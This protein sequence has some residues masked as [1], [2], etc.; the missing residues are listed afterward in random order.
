[1]LQP[2]PTWQL[3]QP[4]SVPQWFVEVVKTYNPA[5][6]GHYLAQLLWQRGR[7]EPEK[8]SGFLVPDCYQPTSPFAFGQEMKW[9]L[10]RLQQ[11]RTRGE[12]V[13]IWGDFDADGVTA[14]SLL[15]EGLGQ[16]FAQHQQLSYYIPNRNSESHGLNNPGLERLAA[17]G[18]QLIVTCDTGST[19]LGE[20]EKAHQLGIDI[21]ITDH[22]T[23]PTERPEVVSIINPRYFATTHPLY[24][25]SGVAVAYKLIEAMYQ[26]W[27]IIP[28]QPLEELLDLVAIGLIADLVELSGDCRYLAQ[29]GIQQLQK[30]STN[31]TRPGVAHLLKR[32]RVSG[33]RPTDISFGLGPRLN[34]VSRIHGDASFCVELL[35]SR[36]P[37]RTASLAQETEL[38]N[39]RRKS[40]QKELIKQVKKK[41]A[42][43]DLSTT[44]VIVLEDPQW[45]SGVLGL[46]AG[47]I[48][49]EYGRP[50]ILLTTADE[51]EG[52]LTSQEQESRG[53]Q[54]KETN[55]Q[56]PTASGNRLIARGSARSVN[57]LDLYELVKSQ[58]HLLHRFGGHPYAA[59][60]SLPVEN[61]SL[62]REAI[63]QQLRQ[64]LDT[65][66]LVPMIEVDLIVSV[67]ELGQDLFRELKLLE[68]CGM[69]NP[70]TKLLIKNCWFQ[71]VSHNNLKDLFGNKVQYIKTTFKIYDRSDNKGFPG[72]WWGHYRE[73]IPTEQLCDAIVELDFNTFKQG[74]YEV[75]LI[76]LRASGVSSFGCTSLVP[77]ECLLDWRGKFSGGEIYARFN[78]R[79]GEYRL[80]EEC[81]H[82]WSQIVWEYR[83]AKDH[84]QKLALAYHSPSQLPPTQIWQQLVGIAKYLN[85]TGK[86]ATV[87]QLIE[88][89]GLSERVLNLGLIALRERG[90]E[91]LKSDG[92]IQIN[93][94]G[95][96]STK[97]QE[98]P[99]FYSLLPSFNGPVSSSLSSEVDESIRLFMWAVIEEQFQR[100]YFFRTPVSTLQQILNQHSLG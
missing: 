33:A 62:F 36:E 5:K 65:N 95:E 9:A 92:S 91:P 90:F 51:E 43:I 70:V 97:A 73:E 39:T 59:G 46:V 72:V 89:L 96:L 14:T 74:Q 22:H 75:R 28:Q 47:Q 12:K 38:A 85:R 99:S 45:P 52:E 29:L 50:T 21:I 31:P 80:L 18:T 69:G 40:L 2:Q 27:P 17:S 13:T 1:M 84:Q 87:A 3:P 34:A 48:A 23:L 55:S 63:N 88:K 67:A 64:Q 93:W 42:R 77:D 19:N 16:F 30:Q 61:I 10:L 6:G 7:Q 76:A 37:T 57:Q 35:T 4:N 49:Q 41:L 15:W 56:Q 83:M 44:S 8:L 24:H 26:T 66:L 100:Q 79:P 32:C 98:S 11:A 58:E 81:P 78:E 54:G 82:S 20:I 71:Q 94:V 86:S 68:P 53:R 60:L 25:L